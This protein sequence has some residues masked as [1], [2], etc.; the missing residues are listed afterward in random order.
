[1]IS[2]RQ[3]W[4]PLAAAV[5]I[6]AEPGAVE[7]LARFG[8][9]ARRNAAR[10]PDCTCVETINRSYY[11]A[12]ISTP[13][14]DCDALAAAKKKRGYKLTLESTDRV[15]L[16]VRT[17][18]ADEMYSWP[19]AG[20]FDARDLWEKIGYGPG[21]SGPFDETLRQV[22][23]GD[24][25]DFA[26]QGETETGGRKLYQYSFRV[27]EERSHWEIHIGGQSVATSWDGTL[28]IDPETSEPARMTTR[29]SELPADAFSCEIDTAAD[30]GHTA[31]GASDVL[32]ARET[33][34]RYIDRSGAEV[35]SVVTFS[36]CR[37]LPAPRVYSGAPTDP[38]I[39]LDA[40][41]DARR[42]DLPAG[43]PVEIELTTAIDSATAAAGDRF[44]GNVVQAV[45]DNSRT[46][47]PA[48]SAVAGRLTKVAVHMQPAEVAIVM[49]VETVNIHGADVPVH[50]AGRFI[51]KGGWLREM[52]G[53][54]T[55]G[56]GA[57]G[58]GGGAS[59]PVNV[60]HPPPIQGE[61]DALSF[62][63]T[64]K[65]LDPGFKTEWLTVEPAQP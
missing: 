60:I 10:L 7:V 19:G 27:P 21:S 26:F 40:S 59:G 6:A 8:E 41:A 12:N 9:I 15:R 39:A 56:A 23:Q 42:L 5:C 51:P 20:R 52:L 44:A 61:T 3:A 1:M 38:A 57:G 58:G 45:R 17:T 2:P 4:L 35:E 64:H 48:G 62:P 13:L 50:L 16:D 28:L 63:G 24:A 30:Y 55:V 53:S 25:I 36:D 11:R 43:L 37:E 65:T 32:L 31:I 34:E 33:H 14:R 46:L 29:T 18:V 49:H 47:V 54:L 22:V